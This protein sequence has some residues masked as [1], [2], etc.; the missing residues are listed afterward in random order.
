MDDKLILIMLLGAQIKTEAMTATV[1]D[2][3]EHQIAKSENK[4]INEVREET[5]KIIL[6][7][8]VAASKTS[9]KILKDI[10]PE[11]APL[12]EEFLKPR[13]EQN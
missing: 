2:R 10:A 9:A 7:N 5:K 3:L 1:L 11:L 4:S 6:A 13:P 12:M 8:Q